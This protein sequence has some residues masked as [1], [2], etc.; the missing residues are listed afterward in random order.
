MLC[1]DSANRA[2]IARVHEALHQHRVIHHD[3]A[4][5]GHEVFETIHARRSDLAHFGA[6]EITPPCN[7]HVK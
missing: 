7:R 6:H 3:R 1:V 5:V 2:K 4:L